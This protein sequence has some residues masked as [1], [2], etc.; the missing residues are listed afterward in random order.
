MSTVVDIR[1][2]KV[3]LSKWTCQPPNV[4]HGFPKVE[5]CRVYQNLNLIFRLSTI[6]LTNII[7]NA[8]CL[9]SWKAMTKAMWW[10]IHVKPIV[11]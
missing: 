7:V 8:T 6:K 1:V 2:L 9:S 3:N 4:N 11:F 5:T 10:I